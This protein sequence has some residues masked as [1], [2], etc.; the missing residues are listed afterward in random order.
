L[1][2]IVDDEE[3]VRRLARE[4]LER[5]GYHVMEAASG[6]QAL[7]LLET[8][9]ADLLLTD[10]VMP[11]M[12]G[13]ALAAVAHHRWPDLHVLFMSGFAKQYASELSGSVCLVKP[14]TAAEV[15]AAVHGLMSKLP[16]AGTTR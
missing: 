14:F 15:L 12:S 5:A 3:P 13:L 4:I 11:G 1:I 8:F 16:A 7:E 10:I 9:A 2:V 6:R